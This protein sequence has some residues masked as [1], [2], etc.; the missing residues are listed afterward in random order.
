MESRSQPLHTATLP[1][2]GTHLIEA[3]AGT[4]KTFTIALLYLRLILETQHNTEEILVV[5]FT[6]AA[7]QELRER[8]RARIA[9]AAQLLTEATLAKADP[10]LAEVLAPYIQSDSHTRQTAITRLWHAA[11]TID[12]AAI[13]TIHGFCQ[14][15][16][17]E[18]P[19]ECNVPFRMELESDP[20]PL[21]LRLHQNYWRNAVAFLPIEQLPQSAHT[22]HP[23][24][25]ASW[26]KQWPES[27]RVVPD[28]ET[29][30]AE[31]VQHCT[32][33]QAARDAAQNGES[34]L[35]EFFASLLRDG[36]LALRAK[37]LKAWSAHGDPALVVQELRDILETSDEWQQLEDFLPDKLASRLK[38]GHVLPQPPKEFDPIVTLYQTLQQASPA[39]SDPFLPIK[40]QARQYVQSRTRDAQQKER[41]VFFD[42][43][44][45]LLWQNLHN[46]NRDILLAHLQHRF[47]A[48]LIDEFQDTDPRQYELFHAIFATPSHLLL[49]IGDP[50]QA[51]Y[52]FRGADLFTYLRAKSQCKSHWS[53]TTNYRSSAAMISAVNA[54]FSQHVDPFRASELLRGSDYTAAIE[55]FPSQAS[56]VGAPGQLIMNSVPQSA[57]HIWTTEEKITKQKRS[58]VLTGVASEISRL[59]SS[60]THYQARNGE[61]HQISAGDIAILVRTNQ[62]AEQMRQVLATIGIPA[63]LFVDSSVF[64]T[65]ESEDLRHLLHALW[66][67]HRHDLLRGAMLCESWGLTLTELTL[68]MESL[69][70]AAEACHRLWQNSGV[71]HALSRFW[72]DTTLSSDGH[73]LFARLA[74]RSDGERRLANLRH[75]SEMVHEAEQAGHL[76]GIELLRWYDRERDN[77]DDERMLRLESDHQRV[78]I[79]TVHRAKGLEFPI[80]FIPCG[81][82]PR[83]TIAQRVLASGMTIHLPEHDF[84]P[85]VDLGSNNWEQH[86]TRYQLE[87]HAEEIRLLYVALTRAIVRCYLVQ[88]PIEDTYESAQSYLLLGQSELPALNTQELQQHIAKTLFASTP[89]GAISIDALPDTMPIQY[90]TDTVANTPLHY[91]RAKRHTIAPSWHQTSFTAL[92]HARTS[93][94]RIDEINDALDD[95]IDTPAL[96]PRDDVLPSGRTMGLLLHDIFAAIDFA[97]TTMLNTASVA[98][99]LSRYGIRDDTQ[100]SIAN[101][102]LALITHV[103][104]APLPSFGDGASS[105]S[106]QQIPRAARLSELEFH[107][108]ICSLSQ[109]AWSQLFATLAAP[110]SPEG[111]LYQS[112]AELSLQVRAGFVTGSIDL[113]CE[114]NRRYAL[115][116]YKSNLLG[117]HEQAYEIASLHHAMQNGKYALQYL[118][119]SVA[120]HRYLQHRLANYRYCDHFG[121]VYYLF[122]R[123]MAYGKGVF[124]VMPA[125]EQIE[126]LSRA[127]G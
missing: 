95:A 54:I 7:T 97:D 24:T 4:G 48:A 123:G 71:L 102:L 119:Y 67:P 30:A 1:L 111:Q 5:T 77:N 17:Q 72:S 32:I 9:E 110:D 22:L 109:H 52:R 85:T 42:D 35:V 31:H 81:W 76:G 62:Q 50:K 37:R 120:L 21:Q 40:L 125:E 114:I 55:Y 89:A 121:G 104:Q 29:L 73:S 117:N 39:S 84:A 75:L 51:I 98:P 79:I 91:R 70:K 86:F 116:D 59:L 13:Y 25:L 66:H 14:R 65:T 82:E 36:A 105:W 78:Q 58:T 20:T 101:A 27:A 12:R 88:P 26:G 2:T 38:K 56:A 33:W 68:R 8:I 6:R 113:V 115:I 60:Q 47:R 94:N 112:I 16:L 57:L 99:Y 19:L 61:R 126:T 92:A 63:T 100:S 18:Y 127:L 43:L 15:I 28:P 44:I 103:V 64:Q 49:M 106:L 108:P 87:N 45:A 3:S 74:Q 46:D 53:L 41:V 23:E 11:R 34:P 124:T 69:Q 83:N 96:T 122:L 107:F 118:L 90:A 80:V 10:A 93:W